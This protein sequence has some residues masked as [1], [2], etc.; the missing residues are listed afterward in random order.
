MASSKEILKLLADLDK[1][2]G[3]T[4][5]IIPR[6]LLSLCGND[7][8]MAIVLNRLLE[9]VDTPLVLVKPYLEEL[10]K[11]SF[12]SISGDLLDYDKKMIAKLTLLEKEGWVAKTYAQW[13][14]DTGL[15]KYQVMQAIQKLERYG[16]ETQRFIVPVFDDAKNMNVASLL[17]YRLNRATFETYL[18]TIQA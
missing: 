17:H 14:T 8:P 3:T 15:S 2:M 11:S 6:A 13:E 12:K 9:W 16:A 7:Y 10:R 1:Q 4:P 5:I 18:Q